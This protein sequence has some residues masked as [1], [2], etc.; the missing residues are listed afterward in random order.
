[1]ANKFVVKQAVK[2]KIY[3][4]I[5]LMSPSGG[6]KTYSA[7]R[8]ATG[9]A[10]EIE[11]ITGSPAKIVMGNTEGARGR[12]YA[13]EFN[14]DIVDLEPPYNPELFVDFINWCVDEGYSIIVLDSSSPEWEG[15]GG[16]LDLQ[17]QAGGKYQDWSK[18][19]PRHE[20]FINA[21]ASSPIHIIAT[22]RGKDQ[23]EVEKDEKGRVSVKKLGVG[24]KQREGFEY[25][26]TCTFAIDRDTHLAKAQKDNTHI[27]D[28][29]FEVILSEDHGKKIINWANSGEGYTPSARFV[30]SRNVDDNVIDEENLKDK[31]SEIKSLV[32]IS[33]K[34]GIDREV[35]ISII[36]KYHSVRGKASANFNSITDIDVANKIIS[37]LKDHLENIL[38]TNSEE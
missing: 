8:I 15:R 13:N 25:E 20:K 5:A 3:T 7:L 35:I 34:N 6:G 29:D 32:D 18:V 9:M 10:D 26:F 19:T 38:K 30:S 21:I 24:A 27:F 1:M 12:Y 33:T 31:I 2:E 37:E 23:Y 17:Q 22:M 14:Y 4:K 36:S 11:K 28:N 16:C